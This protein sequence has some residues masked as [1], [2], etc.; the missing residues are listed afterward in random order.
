LSMHACQSACLASPICEGVVVPANADSLRCYR[1]TRINID[2]CDASDAF[3]LYTVTR[4]W[5]PAPPSPPPPPLPAS[6]AAINERFLS[7]HPVAT[8][9][10][11]GVLVHQSDAQQGRWPWEA[12]WGRL[13]ASLIN[14]EAPFMFSTS[15][16][17]IVLSPEVV[18][19]EGIIYCSYPN[20]GNSMNSGN[21]GC[22]GA[23]AWGAQGLRLALSEQARRG[24]DESCLWGAPTAEDRSH[25]RYNEVVLWGEKFLQQLPR[26]VEAFF[27]PIRGRVDSREGDAESA[28]AARRAFL[29]QF[30]LRDTDFTRLLTFDVAAARRGTAPWAV[31]PLH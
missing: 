13:A 15:A 21:W 18:E 11:C 17:G 14:A 10:G 7:G 27:Y 28:R 16:I 4:Y 23:T 1:K 31:A 9:R 30:G 20:D 22:D 24:R 26:I 8:V 29:D 6:V 3:H 2:V 25:C 5:P 12:T 19:E